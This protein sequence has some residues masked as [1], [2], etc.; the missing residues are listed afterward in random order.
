MILTN[1]SLEEECDPFDSRGLSSIYGQQSPWYPSGPSAQT[2]NWK[3]CFTVALLVCISEIH[4]VPLSIVKEFQRLYVTHLQNTLG[5]K[6]HASYFQDICAQNISGHISS[7]GFKHCC[8]QLQP[9]CL[10]EHILPFVCSVLSLLS[11]RPSADGKCMFHF[12][13]KYLKVDQFQSGFDCT[14]CRKIFYCEICTIHYINFTGH[15]DGIAII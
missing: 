9:R 6:S 1:R 13:D 10:W 4:M 8:L 15:Q 12:R 11:Q 7:N 2:E 14:S 5:I 3:R